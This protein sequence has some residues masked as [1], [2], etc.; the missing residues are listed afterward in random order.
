VS[1]FGSLG[2]NESEMITEAVGAARLGADLVKRLLA[3]SGRKPLHSQI[4]NPKQVIQWM[5]GLLARTLGDDIRLT[6]KMSGRDWQVD[7]DPSALENALLNMAIN[8]RDAMPEGGELT[9]SVSNARIAQATAIEGLNLVPRDYVRIAV[10]DTGRGM[11]PEIQE[12]AFEPF[13]TSKGPGRGTGLGLSM[14]YGFARGSGGAARIASEIG[15]GTTVEIYLPRFVDKTRK[16]KAPARH[17]APLSG[18]G[19]ILLVE[20]EGK[21]RSLVLRSLRT[22]GYE[23]VDAANGREALAI[24]ADDSYFDLLLTDMEMPEGISGLDLAIQVGSR[25]P[26]IRV[27]LMSGYRDRVMA[28]N[29]AWNPQW[30][31]LP[32]PFENDDLA[33]T[34]RTAL[35]GKPQRAAKGA[36]R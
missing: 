31:F 34:V 29:D 13:F 36:K 5:H 4:Y 16:R 10:S 1:D 2:A 9:V 15:K 22:M 32:K 8:S 7:T 33:S 28:R 35:S 14:V 21:V 11:P 25:F 3:F 17:H 6:I 23:V 26:D 19:R 27:V 12:H 20:D 24:L 18:S 30:R